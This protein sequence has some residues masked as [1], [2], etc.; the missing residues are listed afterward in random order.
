M[1][2]PSAPSPDVLAVFFGAKMA[3]WPALRGALLGAQHLL[4]QRALDDSAAAQLVSA[5]LAQVHVPSLVA[6]ERLIALQCLD[7]LAT[8]HPGAVRAMGAPLLEGAAA[9][10]DG[11]KEPRCL[12]AGFSAVASL[13]AADG[14]AWGAEP[15]ASAAQELHDQLAAYFPL[16]YSPPRGAE[17][18]AVAVSRE[19]LAAALTS[20]L[21]ASPAFAPRTLALALGTLALPGDHP[22]EAVADA[23]DMRVGFLQRRLQLAASRVVLVQFAEQFKHLLQIKAIFAA[24]L[25]VGARQKNLHFLRQILVAGRRSHRG[26]KAWRHQ[27]RGVC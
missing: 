13:G 8:G 17:A 2:L 18:R 7:A 22:A 1:A 5:M 23:L 21:V 27:R 10:L 4:S 9:A 15:L 19:A 24:L 20:A 26:A 11:E 3:D 14:S 25:D 6:T 12:R 16:V